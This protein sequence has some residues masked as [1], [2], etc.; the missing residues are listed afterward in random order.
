M[1]EQTAPDPR[2]VVRELWPLIRR[3]T[4]LIDGLTMG[5]VDDLFA[6]A[7]TLA[8][9]GTIIR[10]I[11]VG[12]FLRLNKAGNLVEMMPVMTEFLNLPRVREMLDEVAGPSDE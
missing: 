1:S 2:D 12:V 9:E 10:A 5:Q 6:A 3:D 11:P 7:I 4:N 8:C